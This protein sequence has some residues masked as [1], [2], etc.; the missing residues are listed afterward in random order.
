MKENKYFKGNVE[1]GWGNLQNIKSLIVSPS[2][3]PLDGE[4]SVPGSKSLTNRALILGAMAEGTSNLK[5]I[6][7]SDDSYWCVESLKSL[8]VSI[9]IKGNDA[10]VAGGSTNF[11]NGEI[12][13]GSAGTAARFL[14]GFLAA[15][16]K[17]EWKLTASDNMKKRPIGPLIQTL[18]ELGADIQYLE[19]ENHYPILI[20]GKHLSGGEV[21]MSGDVSSQFISGLLMAAPRFKS[22]L[23]IRTDGGIV[24]K[25][26]VKMT[27]ELMK[28]FGAVV[29]FDDNLEW[30]KVIP[31][32]YSAN[33]IKI[34]ADISAACYFMALAAVTGGRIKINN[35]DWRTK[36]PD[37]GM[38][39]IFEEMG[40]IVIKADDYIELRGPAQ[41]KGGFEVSLKEMS[42]Q[43]LTLA[44]TAIFSDG[45]VIVKNVGHIRHHE[46]DRLKVICLS[47]KKIGINVQVFD[48]GFKIYPGRPSPSALDTYD[49]HR[50]AMSLALIGT[51]IPGVKLNDPGCVSKT[52]PEYFSVL[53]NLGIEIE[54]K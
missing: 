22:P 1:S 27:L 45:P 37:I 41:L 35:I 31:S 24:Q 4:I 21:K 25:N 28:E 32:A 2:H 29:E 6:L 52:F 42:D 8:G 17:G 11:N 20:K 48:D 40:C 26:Y 38:L 18:Y 15:A 16:G 43:A 7:K 47:M 33:D 12:Y 51:K 5:G 13:V 9:K 30:M 50:V 23:I 3:R 39:E 49:D 36:Q 46:S 53:K 54:N 10:E 44:V 14:P 19:K 34:E